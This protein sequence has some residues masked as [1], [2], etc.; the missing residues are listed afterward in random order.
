MIVGGL[1]RY[2]ID[3]LLSGLEIRSPFCVLT[4]DVHSYTS[5]LI[6]TYTARIVLAYVYYMLLPSYLGDAT[7]TLF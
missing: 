1:G 5:V 6:D 7:F 4:Y 3:V 2:L